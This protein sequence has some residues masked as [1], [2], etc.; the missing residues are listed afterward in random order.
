MSGLESR[1]IPSVMKSQP[2]IELS[3]SIG[4]LFG[5]SYAIGL[6]GGDAVSYS[7]G[8]GLDLSGVEAEVLEVSVEGW[9]EFRRV[10]DEA[11]VWQW[12]ERY[13]DR[14]VRDGTIWFFRVTY[15]D[16]SVSTVGSNAYPET[17]EMVCGALV[18]LVGGRPFR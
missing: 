16:G 8:R 12:R 18:E 14:T 5:T 1:N 17:Y 13:E 15:P 4:G 6:H 10:L 2:P 7:V 9:R 3:A 11:G